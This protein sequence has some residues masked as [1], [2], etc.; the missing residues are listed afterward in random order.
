MCFLHI[1]SMIILFKLYLYLSSN[2]IH[3]LTRTTLVTQGEGR[4]LNPIPTTVIK[5]LL[6]SISVIISLYS[7]I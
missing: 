3:S 1:F 6:N 5:A 7:Y 4:A 2:T